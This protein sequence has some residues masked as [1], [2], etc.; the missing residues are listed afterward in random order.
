MATPKS[1][2]YIVATVKIAFDPA[3]AP[4]DV[5][6][7]SSMIDCEGLKLIDFE[8]MTRKSF[9]EIKEVNEETKD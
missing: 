1:K 2:K 6:S 4:V 3:N 7:I 8:I 9:D 5:N